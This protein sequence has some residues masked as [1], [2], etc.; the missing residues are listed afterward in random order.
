MTE[1]ISLQI[2]RMLTENRMRELSEKY[3]KDTAKK[4]VFKENVEMWNLCQLGLK[5]LNDN[6][7]NPYEKALSSIGIGIIKEEDKENSNV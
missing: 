3:G 2:L 1:V 4:Q 6:S 5:H 7:D